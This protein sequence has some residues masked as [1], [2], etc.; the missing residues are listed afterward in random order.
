M[1]TEKRHPINPS[2]VTDN[3][4]PRIRHGIINTDP[5]LLSEVLRVAESTRE[6]L[7]ANIITNRGLKLFHLP[8][9]VGGAMLLAVIAGIILYLLCFLVSRIFNPL[10][11]FVSYSAL[12]GTVIA[13]FSYPIVKLLYD[14][15][16]PNIRK[17][18]PL[19]ANDRALL[20]VRDWFVWFLDIN[21]Q[22]RIA[23]LVAGL[24][25][26]TI[27]L[28]PSYTSAR[29]E[30]GSYLLVFFTYFGLG[31]GLYCAIIIP[32]LVK[33]A[34]N[35]R[36]ELFWLKP[37]DSPAVTEV[38]ITY[39]KLTIADSIFCTLGLVG[40]YWLKPWESPVVTL[41]SALWLL[42]GLIAVTYSFVYPQYYLRNLILAEK[43]RQLLHVQGLID[44]YRDK[45]PVLTKE[46]TERLSH[47]FFVYDRLLGARESGLDL[48]VFSRFVASLI[49]PIISF[50]VGQI[51]W[52]MIL[53]SIQMA[54]K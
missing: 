32:S 17:I 1:S 34:S 23:A 12:V 51:D 26:A 21:R 25:F 53:F 15:I 3:D 42:V 43:Q 29:F 36:W 8:D 54:I 31:Q 45:L 35:E 28:V 9:T 22:I 52:T 38:K 11:P 39:M 5:K 20:K 47:L 41:I 40:L 4:V 33:A 2:L 44:T 7:L 19:A 30:V 13:T 16:A 6:R 24:G 10:A 48:S 50:F 46:D 27:V 14:D 18:I 49:F 37:A